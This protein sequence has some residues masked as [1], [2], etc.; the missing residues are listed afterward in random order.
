MSYSERTMAFHDLTVKHFQ[1]FPGPGIAW[2]ITRFRDIWEDAD[3]TLWI[4]TDG[5]VTRFDGNAWSTLGALDGLSQC[6][7]RE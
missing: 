6:R 4:A 5:G 2:P 3:G 7:W 1:T